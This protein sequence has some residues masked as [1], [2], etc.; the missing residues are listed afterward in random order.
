MPTAQR[1]FEVQAP[2][3]TVWA[4]LSNL[5]RLGPCL[6]GCTGVDLLSPTEADWR[7]ETKI[8]FIRK[9]FVVRTR[10]TTLEE[11]AHAAW[12]GES[13][14]LTASGTIDVRPRAP[15]RTLLSS[16][17]I[18]TNCFNRRLTSSTEVPLPRATRFR[19]LPFIRA[20]RRRSSRVIESMMAA[21]RTMRRGSISAPPRV[22]LACRAAPAMSRAMP[23][24]SRRWPEPRRPTRQ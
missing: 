14:D 9:R 23:P 18:C 19:R 22:V 8:G 6:P 11:P 7:M 1:T 10:T 3:A 12:T 2:A 24:G 4:F 5:E 13:D 20:G 15:D 21:T 17:R 16:R